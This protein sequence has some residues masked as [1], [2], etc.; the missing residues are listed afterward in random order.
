MYTV[1]K[2]F[3][4]LMAKEL[5]RK[6]VESLLLAEIFKSPKYYGLENSNEDEIS[7]FL[8]WIHPHI[9]VIVEKYNP[10]ESS[11][12][13]YFTIAVRL[14]YRSWKR[15][16]VKENILQEILDNHH[17]QESLDNVKWEVG[18]LEPSYLDSSVQA[19]LPLSTKQATTI[20][21]LALRS[22][23][24]LP[25][26]IIEKIPLL[27]GISREEF[28]KCIEK[29]ESHI[30][31]KR[32]VQQHLERR[33]NRTY[34]C[35]QQHEQELASM[36]DTMTQY[37]LVV[38]QYEYRKKLLEKLRNDRKKISFYPSNKLIEKTLGLSQGSVRR[39]LI[40]ADKQI[41]QIKSILDLQNK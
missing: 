5:T 40:N 37:H 19:H 24:L 29:I 27:T 28:Q 41:A 36:D 38:H 4:Q 18:E 31:G 33:I 30:E 34:I 32:Q 20:L 39:I 3:S 16:I 14:R 6:E 21:V 10:E 26:S 2:I 23:H 22:I 1:N 7:S 12:L 17:Y 9:P 35:C 15:Q 8:L 25:N 13:T 11:F